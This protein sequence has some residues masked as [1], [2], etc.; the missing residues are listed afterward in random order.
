MI[1]D[2]VSVL[3]KANVPFFFKFFGCYSLSSPENCT[4]ID[5]NFTNA[6]NNVSSTILGS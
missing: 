6:L 3:G 4:E 1:L 2:Y 5:L